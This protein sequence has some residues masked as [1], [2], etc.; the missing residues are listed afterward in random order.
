MAKGSKVEL[1]SVMLSAINNAKKQNKEKTPVQKYREGIVSKAEQKSKNI[2]PSIQID[3]D[4]YIKFKMWTVSRNMDMADFYADII[5]KA[6]R[7]EIELPI[8]KIKLKEQVNPQTRGFII[9]REKYTR[10]RTWL[11]KNKTTLKDLLI[12]E[13]KKVVD[14]AEQRNEFS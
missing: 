14:E 3:H 6:L 4:L 9:D 2:Q 7:D 13:V 1:D 5:D 8:P 11:V 10:L 12:Y